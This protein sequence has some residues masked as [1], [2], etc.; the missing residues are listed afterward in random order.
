MLRYDYRSMSY[1]DLGKVFRRGE[2]SMDRALKIASPIVNAVRHE[3]DRALL[4][5]AREYEG[6]RGRSLTVPEGTIEAASSRLSSSMLRSLRLSKNRIQAYH[7]RQRLEGFEFEDSCGAFGQKV[8]PLERVGI[9]VPGGTATYASSV[10]MAAIPAK[11]AG[12]E[13]VVMCTPAKGG[14]VDDTV[15]AAAS[16]AGVNEI[17]PVG[18]AQS[19]AAMAYGTESVRPVLKIVGP[20]GSIVS[21][22]KMLVRQD[23]E[24]DSVAG[25]SEVLIIADGSARPDLIASEMTAQLEHDPAAVAVLVSP[26]SRVLDRACMVLRRTIKGAERREILERSSEQ[27]AVFVKVGS[28]SQAVQFSNEYAPEHLVIDAKSPRAVFKAIRNAGSVFLG[29]TSSVVFGDY[30]SGPNHVLPT[31]GTAKARSALSVYDFVKIVPYQQ[32]SARGAATLAPA[33]ARLAEAEGLPNHA[34]A[35]RLRAGGVR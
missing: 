22:A 5:F 23:C 24:I 2:A 8:V 27:G 31:M 28:M 13:E 35:A 26:S 4:R 15:L 3:G 12:V 20:G 30:C 18:G 32:L 33:V 25:P 21:A 9:Y 19:I 11:V 34:V 6:F 17:V 7:K 14:R 10:L 1:E 16:M 29:G